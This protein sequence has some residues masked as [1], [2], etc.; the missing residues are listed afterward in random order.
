MMSAWRGR[1]ED[2]LEPETHHAFILEAT[3]KVLAF[4]TILI[5]IVVLILLLHQDFSG[6]R[7]KG[8]SKNVK[9]KDGRGGR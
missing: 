9:E 4:S 3:W 2:R 6:E 8:K 7:I 5:L 1:S